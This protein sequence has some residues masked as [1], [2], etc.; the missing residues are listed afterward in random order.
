M[1]A[2]PALLGMALVALSATAALAQNPPP[3]GPGGP[4][5]GMASRRMQLMLNGITLSAQQQTQ[6]DSIVAAI[7]AQMPA[8]TPGAPPDSAARAQRMALS[9]RQDSTIRTLLTPEQQAVWDRN[10]EQ[11]R[12]MMRRPPGE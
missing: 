6:V 5:G 8:F 2:R 12:N 10:A 7:R 9:A 11:A 1:K 4:G 3:G